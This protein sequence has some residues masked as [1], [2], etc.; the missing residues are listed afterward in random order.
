VSEALTYELQAAIDGRVVVRRRVRAPGLRAD[1][2]LDVEEDV[3]VSP[4]EHG[5][6]VTFKPEDGGG[7]GA[8]LS[9]DGK[10][11]FAAGRIVLLTAEDERLVARQRGS[12]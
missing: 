9:F 3:V 8:V 7:G 11:R 4:G 10:L 1:R 5:V 12:Y 6:T 2:P